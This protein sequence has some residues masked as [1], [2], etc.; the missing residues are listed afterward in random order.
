MRILVI[1][2]T[3]FV[4][5]PLVQEL[6]NNGHDVTLFHRGK[7]F[8]SRTAGVPS[9]T[10]DR[11]QLADHVEDFKRLKLDVVL[12]MIP[13]T[14]SDGEDLMETMSGVTPRIVALSSADVYLAY[15]RLHRTEPGPAVPVP[16]NE[17]SSLRNALGP[18]GESYDKISVEKLV[19]GSPDIAG[20]VL[21]LPAIYGPKDELYRFRRYIKPMVDARP[22][23]I[24]PEV[25]SRWRF[26]HEYVDNVAHAVVLAIENERAVGQIFNVAEAEAPTQMERALEIGRLLGWS[27]RVITLANDRCPE[28]LKVLTDLSQHWTVDSSKIRSELGYEGIVPE[29]EALERAIEWQLANPP[30]VEPVEFDYD[31]E[32][33]VLETL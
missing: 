11:Q 23:I 28:S 6:V 26:S 2:G 4:G 1:G 20:T 5:P 15:G 31:A 7:T 24:M 9:L 3:K 19:M 14:L 17:D 12:D 21:R 13:Y 33:A 30:E 29:H 25:L 16:L 18:E 22:A 10:G 8:D 32:D 27:G